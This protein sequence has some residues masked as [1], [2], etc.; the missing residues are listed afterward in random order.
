MFSILWQ[1]KFSLKEEAFFF[2]GSSS[3]I[4]NIHAHTH[5]NC[6]ISHTSRCASSFCG[7]YKCFA[8]INQSSTQ[9]V[10]PIFSLFDFFFI[11]YFINILFLFLFFFISF[12]LSCCLLIKV[13]TEF[14]NTAINHTLDTLGKC[15]QV[16]K[17]LCWNFCWQ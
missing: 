6:N 10:I 17:G 11:F 7:C 13:S 4:H 12:S 5:T 2:V 15:L 3:R 16:I 9:S 1:N 14:C 8:C